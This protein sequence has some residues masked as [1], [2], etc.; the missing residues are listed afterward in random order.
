MP[1]QQ[2]R[3]AGNNRGD[4]V[5][6]TDTREGACGN[7]KS[8]E[9]PALAMDARCDDNRNGNVWWPP[10]LGKVTSYGENTLARAVADSAKRFQEQGINKR[11]QG[12]RWSCNVMGVEVLGN[13][14]TNQTRGAQQMAEAKA[15]GGGTAR[16]RG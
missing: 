2:A 9:G 5:L 16:G 6:A 7:G 1:C 14:T 10:A 8:K 3:V 15:P 12:T 4:P 13:G 11:R